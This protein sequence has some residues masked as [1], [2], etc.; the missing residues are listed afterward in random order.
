MPTTAAIR[1]VQVAY[2]R[3]GPSKMGVEEGTCT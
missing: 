3:V 1:Q 2:G